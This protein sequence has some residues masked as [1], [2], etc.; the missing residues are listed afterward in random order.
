MATATHPEI[1]HRRTA[2]DEPIFNTFRRQPL[3]PFYSLRETQ[4]G[5][6]ILAL[7][8]V[9]AAWVTWR[10]A[11]PE[12]GLFATD[13][14]LLSAKG[15]AL[16]IY[17]RPLQL[18]AESGVPAA[19]MRL[20]P[21]PAAVVPAGWQI[22][23]PP[24]MFDAATVYNK[25]DGRETFYKAYGFEKLHFLG[26]ASSADPALTI[27]IEL[28]DLGNIA[29]A[30]G[31]LIAEVSRPDTTAIHLSGQTLWYTT[32]NSGFL[33][34]GRF[35]A[36]L[37]GS[38]DH[39]A[40]REKVA[41][42]RDA[43]AA[44]LPGEPLPWAYELF[45]GQLK[46]NLA[47]IQYYAENAFSFGFANEFYVAAVPDGDTELLLSRRA[48][49]AAAVQ[50]AAQLGAGFAGFG[51]RLPDAPAGTV[52]VRNG[53]TGMVDGVRAHDRYVIGVRFA[54]SAEAARQ[55][56]DKLAGLLGVETPEAEY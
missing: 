53:Y 8:A 1:P 52:L 10:G 11:H 6:V 22:S 2:T 45:V 12:P 37:I 56:L 26:L 29:N 21:F 42:L 36:R 50:L 27:D 20:D 18:W 35:Y 25:I 4:I 43:L 16:V 54:K 33:V 7:L 9:I 48:D 49:A 47:K 5:L 34:R 28:F 51:Q 13:E 14:Q 17:K 39:E 44:A 31:A 3:R 38:D 55:W 32:R 19:A 41:G 46:L 23:Q 40:I 24:Q 30:L 15:N